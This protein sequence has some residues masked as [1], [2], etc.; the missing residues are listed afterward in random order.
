[1]KSWAWTTSR[2]KRCSHGPVPAAAVRA[3]EQGVLAVQGDGADRPLDGVGVELDAA[4]V[5]DA[6]QAR[7]AGEGVADRL[8]ERKTCAFSAAPTRT[9][10][11]CDPIVT[12][13]PLENSTAIEPSRAGGSEPAG[14]DS[15]TGMNGADAS[16]CA[17]RRHL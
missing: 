7:P 12:R 10:G 16:P 9:A 4:V 1:M 8:G 15:I 11:A 6:G 2:G 13:V 14:P 5:K 3:G 17:A